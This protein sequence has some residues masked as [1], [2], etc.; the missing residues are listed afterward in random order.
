MKEEKEYEVS[1]EYLLIKE[2]AIRHYLSSQ[3]T[4]P[5]RL[6][7]IRKDYGIFF[8]P[9]YIVDLMVSLIDLERF[10]GKEINILEPACGLAQFLI[11][12][13]EIY[14]PFTKKRGFLAL[15]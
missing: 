14:L 4:L 13:K 2:K 9:Q 12:I 15:K 5:E 3:M 11:G 10:S 7:T 1:S 6:K 8:T